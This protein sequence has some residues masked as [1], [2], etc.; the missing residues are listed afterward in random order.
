MG[1]N[2]TSKAILSTAAVV[3]A[4]FLLLA[5]TVAVCSVARRIPSPGV[6]T[7]G[8][9]SLV[10]EID[11]RGLTEE[12]KKGLSER[13]IRVLQRRIDPDNM[14]NLVW[15]PLGD[16][17]FEIQIPLADA[18]ARQRRDEYIKAEK[19]LLDRNL[20][21]AEILRSLEQPAD[22]RTE[23]FKAFAQGDPNRAEIL[24]RLAAVHDEYKDLKNRRDELYG[25]IETTEGQMSSAGLDIDQVN[26]KKSEWAK[27]EAQELEQAL[28]GFSDVNDS[29][30]LLTGYVKTFSEWSKVVDELL[31]RQIQYKDARGPVDRLNLSR[32]QLNVCLEATKE[33]K[34]Q[35]EKLKADF[36]DRVSEIDKV[37]AAYDEYRSFRGRPDNQRD[38]QRMLK[39]AGILEFRILPTTDDSEVDRNLLATYV[40]RLGEEGPQRASDAMYKWFVI[41]NFDDWRRKQPGTVVA[42]FGGKHYVLASNRKDQTMLHSPG[43]RSWKLERA[44]PSTDAMGRRAVG[45]LLDDRGGD[46]LRNIT[47]KNIGRPLCI[48][49]DDIAISAPNIEERLRK[50]SII[51]GSFT[52]MEV[53]EI[54]DRL[55]AGCLPAPLVEQPISVRTI[56]ESTDGNELD[57]KAESERNLSEDRL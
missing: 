46:L 16:H 55:N 22:V 24:G 14:K 42:P 50:S 11:T 35:I 44:N 48:L 51:S 29:R 34:P 18:E 37:V 43:E 3:A 17:R 7:T 53:E 1:K 36:P 2:V 40:T 6:D 57:K 19:A 4:A 31:A 39:G 23:A 49:L 8:G 12:Q 25:S 5:C 26:I 28:K 27:L 56:G 45:F 21:P 13:M 47:G 32:D 41:E 9:T 38:L 10:Y 30:V 52:Q 33:R 15:R 54:A 20:S